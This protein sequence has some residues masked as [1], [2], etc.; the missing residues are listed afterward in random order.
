[1][2]TNGDSG[3]TNGFGDLDALSREELIK[4]LEA[5]AAGGGIQISFAGKANAR[6]LARKVRPRTTR[7]IKKYSAGPEIDQAR[8]LVVEGDNLQALATLYRERG[9]VDLILADPPYNTGKDF[10]YNDRWEEDPND[11]GLGDV[12]TADDRARHTKWMRGMWPRLQMMKAMLRPEGVLAICIDYRE[13]FRLGQMLDE[14]FGEEN[15]LA[16]IN[17]QKAYSP[18]SDSGHVSTA[19]EY[20]LVYA[21]NED[22]A[23][24]GLLPRTA[25]MDARYTSPDGDARLWASGD[26]C[27]GSGDTHQGM[28][29]AIQSPFTG[30]LFYPNEGDCWRSDKK[31]MKQWLEE[32][33]SSYIEKNIKDGKKK[34]L[35]LN[36]PVETA[37]VIA[38]GR[39]E[40]GNW[41][42]LYFQKKGKGKPRLKR[43]LEEIKQGSVPTTFWAS[44]D[45]DEPI[46]LESVSWPHQE[47]GHSQAGVKE[48]DA[49]VGAGHGFE[50]V[51]PLKLFMKVIQLWCPPEGLVL[52]PFAGTGTTGHAVLALNA[53]AGAA[54]RFILVEQGRPEKGDSYARSLLADRL[55]RVIT[56]DWKSAPQPALPGGYRFVTLEKKVDAERLLQME[57]EEMVDTVIASHFDPSRK[58]GGGLELVG[59]EAHRYLVARNSDGEGFFLVWDGPDG[60]TDFT[61]DVYGECA[62][63]AARADLKPR[64]HVYARLYLYQT[65]NVVFY[66]IPDRIL[67]D[68]GLDLKSE[69]FDEAVS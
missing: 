38:R 67:A 48:L 29:Y 64:Y 57:R 24:T 27:A 49:I 44:E 62:Q 10:R 46:A 39:Y 34:A 52:D 4:L 12:V 7:S 18:K 33:G 59:D 6:T 17:W 68:F 42:R 40:A 25:E 66:Q 51:K 28:I 19:T 5:Q 60:N 55:Q 69:P 20:V 63:E 45:Y 26:P 13:L 54:R 35:L 58:R 8:N 37:A 2:E 41:P 22:R 50:T 23:H 47:S 65:D 11:P 9:Q 16:I 61:E 31:Y 56:G 14:L 43:Y 53:T 1:M 36:V 21:R 3:S 15:R 30:E 32:W